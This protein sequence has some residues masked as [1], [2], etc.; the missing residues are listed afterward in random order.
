[1]SRL[2]ECRLP[3]TTHGRAESHEQLEQRLERERSKMDWLQKLALGLFV[4]WLA[5]K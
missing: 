5:L 4:L 1:M 2:P 3:G